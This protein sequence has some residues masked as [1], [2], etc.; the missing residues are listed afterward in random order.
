MTNGGNGGTGDDA[1]EVFT[2]G[3]L[4]PWFLVSL[5]I[6]ADDLDPAAITRLLGIEPALARRK[7]VALASRGGR[8]PHVPRTG[9]WSTQIT[10]EELPGASVEVATATI[11][12]RVAVSPDTWREAVSGASARLRLGLTLDDYNRGLELS[13]AILRRAAELDLVLEIDVYDGVPGP[14][15][16]LFIVG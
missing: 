12:A 8:P 6:N 2:F 13:P 7:G 3:G 10:P 9:V 16:E 5:V 1:I 14:R 11:L 4:I 15:R